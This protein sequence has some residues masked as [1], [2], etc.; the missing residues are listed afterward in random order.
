MKNKKLK[1]FFIPYHAAEVNNEALQPRQKAVCTSAIM[2]ISGV[3]DGRWSSILGQAINSATAKQHG[4]K[5]NNNTKISQDNP[6][7][8]NLTEHFKKVENMAEVTATRVMR[9]MSGEVTLRDS[10]DTKSTFHHG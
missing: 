6:V 4:S 8:R 1:T 9:E 7:I 2:A 5:K 3:G 10:S